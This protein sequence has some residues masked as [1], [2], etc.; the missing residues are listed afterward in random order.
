LYQTSLFKYISLTETV[1]IN[2]FGGSSSTLHLQ[3]LQQP[4]NP[5]Q[6]QA[7]HDLSRAEKPSTWR[8]LKGRILLRLLYRSAKV[9][10][11]TATSDGDNSTRF[12][13]GVRSAWVARSC[14][15][16]GMSSVPNATRSCSQKCEFFAS[17]GQWVADSGP[18]SQEGQHD[19]VQHVYTCLPAVPTPI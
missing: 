7:L 14:P 15:A 3:T 2:P 6:D 19:Q 10:G 18:V 4:V 17:H 5:E 13:N 9:F 8:Y 12:L 16:P 1:T 11:I